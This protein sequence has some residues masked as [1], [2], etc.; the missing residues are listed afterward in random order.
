MRRLGSFIA[1]LAFGM[2]A[3]SVATAA[4]TPA[5]PQFRG[6]NGAGIGLEARPPAIF[7]PAQGVLWKVEV[8]A[9]PSSPCVWGDRIFLS[10]FHDGEL[11]TRCYDRKN[12]GL[13]WTRGVKPPGVELFH[14]MEGSP[15]ASTPATDGTHVVSY[16]GSFGVLCHDLD[17]R[18]L[19]RHPLPMA[20]TVGQYG[21]GASPIIVGGR[22]LVNRDQYQYSSLL[23]LD[24][25]T[26]GKL[27]EA[28]R[29]DVAGSFGT[30]TLWKNKGVDEI[31]LG[32]SARVRGYD[33]ATGAERWMVE[34]ITRFVCTTAVVGGDGILYFGGWSSGQAD[35]PFARW[36]NFLRAYN[37]NGDKAVTF[38][39]TPLEKRD[40]LRGL[41]KNR[42]GTLTEEDFDLL[43]A[44]DPRADNVLLAIKPGGTGDITETHVAWKYRRALPYVPSPL[45]YEG[46]IYF[47]KDGGVLSSVDAKTGEAHYAQQSIDAAGNYFASP[48]AADGRI[49][50]ASSLGKVTVVK[51]GG[52]APEILHQADFGARIHAT[53]VLVGETLYVRT[54]TH[55]WALGK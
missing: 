10:T 37:K 17:G 15:A 38:D 35:A 12:G 24:V 43:R 41:D 16:F 39:E 14:Q 2:A 8:P 36:E 11:Q 13:L 19:W 51:A 4:S 3:V 18:E 5:W 42:D 27:W 31:V 28:S 52:S 54:A 22:V 30:P 46:R 7:G 23:A 20:E 25:K 50:L 47:V 49:F 44:S 1:L 6:V 48:V 33:L 9:S 29:P 53:P 45:F 26:G 34:G 21:S 55:L 40:S 32:G